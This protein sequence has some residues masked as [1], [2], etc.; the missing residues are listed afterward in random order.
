MKLF[1]LHRKKILAT[2]PH[3]AVD[4]KVNKLPNI[5]TSNMLPKCFKHQSILPLILTVFL[6]LG[7]GNV[8]GQIIISQVY[9]GASNNKW[10][11][12]TNVG[13]S[14]L[15]LE[16][17]VQYKIG[18]WIISQDS[19]NG[20]ISGNP[21]GSVLLTGS[22]SAG[23]RFLIKNPSSSESVPHN[24]MPTANISN[25]TVCSFNGNDA[26]AI[27]TDT[28][29]IVDAFGHG[30]N[31]KDISYHRNINVLS[32]NSSFTISE[33]TTK[34]LTQVNNSTSL[35]SEYIGTHIYNSST[36]F[37]NSWSNGSPNSTLNAIFDGNYSTN[38]DLICKDLTINAGVTLTISPT[39]TLTVS[40]NLV[41]NGSIVF[42]SDN[43]GTARFGVYGGAPI[44]GT[45]TTVER[46]L[47]AK[48]AWRLLTAPTK[49]GSNN[50]IADNW[51]GT[52][53]EGVLLW[54]PSGTG[55]EAGPQNNIYSYNGTWNAITNTNTTELFD[56]NKNNAFLVFVTGPHGAANVIT[57]NANTP[58][59][60]AV[61]T[62][63]KPKG[64]L[65]TGPVTTPTLAASQFHLL[66]NPYA[67]PINT[68][69]LRTTNSS[70]TFYL[71]DPTLGNFGG[72]Y[73]YNGSSWT[74][75]APSGSDANIQSGQ[76]F[77]VRSETET[78]F[79]FNES[80]KET[81]N[82]NTWFAKQSVQN[83]SEN[84]IRVLL[85]RQT[86]S[87][88]QLVDGILSVSGSTYANEVDAQ[89][90]LKVSNFNENIQFR[91]GTSNLSIEYLNL[92]TIA[93]EQPIHLTGTS[94]T[95]YRLKV[96][97]EGYVSADIQPIL[98]DT[99][100][101]TNHLI[102]TDGTTIEI[103]FTGVVSSN[104]TPDNRFKIVYQQVLGIEQSISNMLQVY[105]NPVTEGQFAIVLPNSNEV[106]TYEITNYLGQLVQKGELATGNTNV[107]VAHQVAGVYLIKV[108]QN[109]AVYTTKIVKK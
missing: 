62:T 105:P 56:A 90:A 39:H 23:G 88:W 74:P 24:P 92:P 15:N 73:T 99:Q 61:A 109:G 85:D 66:A 63:L 94:A 58:P 7:V 44:S 103:P 71:L 95:N 28:N 1:I 53:A 82:S 38:D 65:I 60:N 17:P 55:L 5:G 79:T 51:Q 68:A 81:G 70:F 6:V 9:E 3:A 76:G 12:I 52:N 78:T 42:K 41:N 35:D 40:G 43:T 16:S 100:S 32:S 104:S 22:L 2:A 29:T 14:T 30:I 50:K 49:G 13:N 101:G 33:W 20:S 75:S 34:T 11:E 37:T 26:I 93:T 48:R 84:K 25:T 59:D 77:F 91:N 8:W 83:T 57:P 69:A 72:Y 27:F 10:L 46:Y 19:G 108:L 47:P 96:K 31:N 98:Q 80:H 89:D 86:N 67:S 107:S 102:P 45:N 64:Q 97:T 87:Q 54:G 4:S 36:T 18:I 106:A 21:T